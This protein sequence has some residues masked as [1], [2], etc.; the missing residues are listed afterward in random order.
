LIAYIDKAIMEMEAKKAGIDPGVRAV[1][2]E[3]DAADDGRHVR[4]RAFV[5]GGGQLSL[6]AMQEQWQED[7]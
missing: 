7:G 2:L 3:Y 6:G 1:S 4:A 5:E